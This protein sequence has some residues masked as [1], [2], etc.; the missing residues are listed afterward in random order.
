MTKII[1]L[2]DDEFDVVHE[3]IL[4][5]LRQTHPAEREYGEAYDAFTE[6]AGCPLRIG[7]QPDRVQDIW[8]KIASDGA[9]DPRDAE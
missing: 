3:L 4:R 5:G 8:S 7:D 9:R 1:E 6:S 2:E